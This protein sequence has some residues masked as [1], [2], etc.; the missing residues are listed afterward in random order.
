MNETQ[1]EYNIGDLVKFI[2]DG[3]KGI[4]VKVDRKVHRTEVRVYWLQAK[5][6][7][8]F[9]SDIDTYRRYIQLIARG[10]SNE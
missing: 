6:F 5:R 4:V 7:G 2:P 10:H 9:R 1:Y 8:Q 3:D